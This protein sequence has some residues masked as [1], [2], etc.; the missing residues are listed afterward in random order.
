MTSIFLQMNNDQ[1]LIFEVF[2]HP[3]KHG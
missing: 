2:T 3:G 1:K